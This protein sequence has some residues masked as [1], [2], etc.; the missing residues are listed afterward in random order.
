MKLFGH[1]IGAVYKHTLS[2]KQ[3]APPGVS[4]IAARKMWPVTSGENCVVAVLDT[5]IDYT[6]PDLAGNII[7]GISMIAGE[8]DYRDENGHGTHVAGTIAANGK[9]LGV[10]PQAKLLAVKVLD[11][12]GSGSYASISQGIAWARKWQ[13]PGGEKVNV[14]NMS[15]GGPVPNNSL[16]KEITL[17]VQAGISVVCAAG[18]AGDGDPDT[19][20]LSFP[21]YYE[22]SL[23]VGAI[24]LQVGLANFS[25][26]NERIDI[27]APGVDTYSTYPD[28]RYVELSGTSMAA[29]HI[30][31]ALALI[32][33]RC[34]KRFG[35]Y[36]T[37]EQIRKLLHY[38]AIDL[39]ETGFDNLAGFGLFSFNIDGG[40]SIKLY[41]NQKVYKVNAQ[42]KSLANAPF[43]QN[44]IACGSI[45]EISD[46]LSTDTLYVPTDQQQE[47]AILIWS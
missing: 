14:I 44:S 42:E 46:L 28:N 6:H 32:Y 24:D 20:E 29:P 33:S 36:P 26:S 41:I 4:L 38:Q 7:G 8:K 10:A 11:K 19:P 18:N 34:Y 45:E 27:V 25:N 3:W 40:K 22:E 13:G 5:G 39:G 30:S 23:S 9:L 37:P 35:V 1:G 16:H 12:D 15:L 47:G 31:G 43:M 2:E 21:A 17:A